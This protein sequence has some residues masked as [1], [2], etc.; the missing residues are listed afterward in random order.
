[1]ICYVQWRVLVAPPGN[2]DVNRLIPELFVAL[3]P[4]APSAILDSAGS[5]NCAPSSDRLTCGC[6][7]IVESLSFSI[8]A[9]S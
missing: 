9:F 3:T 5:N 7:A 2:A 1:M 6:D 4:T 8:K